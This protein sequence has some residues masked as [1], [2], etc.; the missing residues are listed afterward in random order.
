MSQANGSGSFRFVLS[1][2]LP[3]NLLCFQAIHGRLN[4][5]VGWSAFFGKG[6]LNL[7][8]G[9]SALTPQRLHDLKFELRQFGFSHFVLYY[10]CVLPYYYNSCCQVFFYGQTSVLDWDKS[11]LT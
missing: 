9:G 11:R 8:D 2:K 1:L 6:F 3:E 5:R 10:A 7:T 4:R